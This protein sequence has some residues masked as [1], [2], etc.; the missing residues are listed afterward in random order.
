[1]I[2]N[3]TQKYALKIVYHLSLSP[4]T[5][6]SASRL[7]ADLKI[8][9]KYLTHILTKLSKSD[10]LSVQRGKDGGFQF[11]HDPKKV[12]LYDI[13]QSVSKLDEHRCILNASQCDCENPCFLH[14]KWSKIRNEIIALLSE[15][16][17]S[18]LE[19]LKIL[20]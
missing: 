17:L 19:S 6:F 15:T 2:L 10:I 4:N 3:Q 7:H 8:P 9:Y 16:S 13:V 1:M 11:V 14:H 12:F 5:I 18:N 20:D